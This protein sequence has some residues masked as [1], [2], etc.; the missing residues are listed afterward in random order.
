MTTRT[1]QLTRELASDRVM[2]LLKKQKISTSRKLF[3]VIAL[4]A[5]IGSTLFYLSDKQAM[6]AWLPGKLAS[7]TNKVLAH[8]GNWRT[9]LEGLQIKYQV[10]LA[11]RKALEQQIVTLDAQMREMQ[12]ELDFFRSNNGQVNVARPTATATRR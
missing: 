2:V 9:E 10:E 1:R 7:D 12:A 8:E 6:A 4:C 5:L 11:A 3:V